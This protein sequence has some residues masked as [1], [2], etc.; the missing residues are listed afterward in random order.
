MRYGG[1]KDDIGMM[2][3]DVRGKVGRVRGNGT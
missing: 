1:Q 2:M 3:K